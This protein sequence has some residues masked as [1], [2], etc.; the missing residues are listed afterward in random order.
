MRELAEVGGFGGWRTRL[1]ECGRLRGMHV[2]WNGRNGSESCH[3]YLP[4]V[5]Q[6]RDAGTWVDITA[7]LPLLP[8]A[9]PSG[10]Q[11]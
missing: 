4:Y 11:R 2:E 10:W 1:S 5:P 7:P 9:Q 8:D 6:G 3:R